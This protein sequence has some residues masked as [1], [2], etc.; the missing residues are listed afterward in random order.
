MTKFFDPIVRVLLSMVFFISVILI[1]NNIFTYG[2]AAFQDQLGKMGVWGVFAPV[3]ILIQSVA[4][5]T[6]IIGYKI[7]ITAYVL[8]AYS[9]FWV[10][11]YLKLILAGVPG[12]EIEVLQYLT[13]AGGLFYMGMH[14]AT[15][16]SIDGLKK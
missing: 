13:I 5:L 6:M 9:L 4:G 15:G 12:G 16:Y 3:T 1:L 8:A 11:V 2:Y 10:I 14:P 7:K